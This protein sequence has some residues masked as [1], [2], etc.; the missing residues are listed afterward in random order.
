MET[1][2]SVNE[3]HDNDAPERGKEQDKSIQIIY[4]IRR[5]AKRRLSG[6]QFEFH[7]KY[8]LSELPLVL[9]NLLEQ[10]HFWSIKI[11]TLERSKDL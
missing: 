2:G 9:F 6:K 8:V 1:I 7:V 5:P 3:A 11:K 10:F 4:A